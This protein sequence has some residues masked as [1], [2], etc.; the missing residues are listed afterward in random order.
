MTRNR[1]KS[2]RKRKEYKEEKKEKARLDKIYGNGHQ[3]LTKDQI[4][5][6]HLYMQSQEGMRSFYHHIKNV[7]IKT[8]QSLEA[9]S[10]LNELSTAYENSL[11]EPYMDGNICV[12]PRRI[13]KSSLA[14]GVLR[15]LTKPSKKQNRFLFSP[16]Y[17]LPNP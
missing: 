6:N 1:H 15:A 11:K 2:W 10:K 17:R 12:C 7:Q 14:L 13:G 9:R 5:M 4:F 3:R 16:A 8:R